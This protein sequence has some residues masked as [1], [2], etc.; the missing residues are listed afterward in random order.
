[1]GTV[2][3]CGITMPVT[4]FFIVTQ[5]LRAW[6]E[7]NHRTTI[8]TI[9]DRHA[10]IRIYIGEV[11]NPW[12][13]TRAWWYWVHVWFVD[14]ALYFQGLRY[15][16]VLSKNPIAEVWVTSRWNA[17]F[18]AD[19]E[20]LQKEGRARIVPRIAH[21]LYFMDYPK[22]EKEY[23]FIIIAT[24][25]RR[26]NVPLFRKIC[27]ETKAKCLEVS[28]QGDI[29]SWSLSEREKIKLLLK[30]KYLLFPSRNEGFG[31]PVLEANLL[32]I[33]A[34]YTNGHALA[35]FA[36]GFGLPV[37]EVRDD[38]EPT[39]HF[40]NF[41][42]DEEEAIKIAKYALS[43]TREEYDAMSEEIKEETRRW[44]LQWID[45]I[46]DWIGERI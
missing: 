32:G 33:P 42:V 22:V 29:K 2:N 31:M 17:S 15:R 6:I 20:E 25:I 9:P 34:L 38:K 40:K 13:R 28:P 1:M 24:N 11:Y 5:N 10:S 8:T 35:D 14:T 36:L 16:P 37:K 12:T 21:P 27:K 44:Q 4:S 26:K 19:F 45:F 7:P 43:L 41:E 18:I 39:G 3:L 46:N 23:D 30:S